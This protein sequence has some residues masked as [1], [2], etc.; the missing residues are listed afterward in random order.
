MMVTSV[1][2]HAAA[3]FL[4][5]RNAQLAA[6]LADS[7][8]QARLAAEHG[9]TAITQAY[10]LGRA[11]QARGEEWAEYIPSA[12][13]AERERIEAAAAEPEPPA[14]ERD[15]TNRELGIDDHQSRSSSAEA[16]A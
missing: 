5:G 16:S 6:Q 11:H 2:H 4:R 13:A 3:R 7:I 12:L 10:D 15:L 14:A 8:E 9:R 1:I